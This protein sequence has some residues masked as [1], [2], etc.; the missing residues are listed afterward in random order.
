MSKRSRQDVFDRFVYDCEVW[1]DLI[2]YFNDF[3]IIW[4]PRFESFI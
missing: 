1:F 4:L 2:C 3:E